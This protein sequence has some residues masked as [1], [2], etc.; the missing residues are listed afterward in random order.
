MTVRARRARPVKS[1]TSAL[2]NAKQLGGERARHGAMLA[3]CFLVEPLHRC[4]NS[5]ER[6][7]NM[8]D[9]IINQRLIDWQLAVSCKLDNE[10]A[11]QRIVG[12]R[13]SNHWQ[14]A[15]T[16]SKIADCDRQSTQCRTCSEQHIG[17]LLASKIDKM[18]QRALI[19]VSRF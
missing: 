16:R 18:K 5:R 14:G 15:K 17:A 10:R 3:H 8:V 4:M 7:F 2:R 12:R 6:P 19:D 11:Q 1:G 9:E 13:E